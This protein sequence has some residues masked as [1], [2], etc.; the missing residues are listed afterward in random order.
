MNNI[1]KHDF[2]ELALR[3][4]ERLGLTQRQMAETLVMSERSYAD[5]E[6]G[7]SACG[8]LTVTLL[9]ISLPNPNDFLQKIRKDFDS[10]Y[11]MEEVG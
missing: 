4:R 10:L 9:L 5:I 7:V 8:A 11:I 2:R 6:S 3:E 1:L